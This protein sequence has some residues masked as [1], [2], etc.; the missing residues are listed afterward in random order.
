MAAEALMA[1]ER[2]NLAA[3]Q[4]VRGTEMQRRWIRGRAAV[5]RGGGFEEEQR[6]IAAVQEPYA[7]ASCGRLKSKGRREMKTLRKMFRGR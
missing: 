2:L 7:E 5:N 6:R 3:V 4:R 1:A